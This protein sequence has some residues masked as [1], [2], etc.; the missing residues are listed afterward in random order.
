[1]MAFPNG[2]VSIPD[3]LDAVD[4]APLLCAGLTTFNALRRSSAQPGDLVGVLGIGGLGHLGVQFAAHMGFRV[5]AIAR[6]AEK[7]A[8]A[9]QL[10]AHHYIDS[11]AGDPAAALRE[12]GGAQVILAT[13]SDSKSMAGLVGGLAPRGRMVIVGAGSDPI[14]VSP[15]QLL[16]GS[17]SIEGALTGSAIDNEDTLA[18]S[19]IQNI[20]PMI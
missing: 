2:L 5:A 1:M 6:G 9:K 10:G 15:L 12:L 20:R 14:E 11:K 8:L 17:R 13:A 19:V 4:A 18:F 16:F 7:E 3:G